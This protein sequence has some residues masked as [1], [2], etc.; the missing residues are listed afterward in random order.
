MPERN[1]ADA[2]DYVLR[3]C[4]QKADILSPI[5]EDMPRRKKKASAN[6]VAGAMVMIY[7]EWQAASKEKKRLFSAMAIHFDIGS[8]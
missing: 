7:P 8:H 2:N 1:D 5:V 3:L 6:L 4:L